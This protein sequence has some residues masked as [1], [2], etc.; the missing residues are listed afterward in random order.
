MG[1]FKFVLRRL[2]FGLGALIA[3]SAAIFFVTQGLPADPAKTILGRDGKLHLINNVITAYGN[4]QPKITN[5]KALSHCGL[6]RCQQIHERK[7]RQLG[8]FQ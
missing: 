2:A 3:I 6:D 1:I 7:R 5:T 8:Q 4:I